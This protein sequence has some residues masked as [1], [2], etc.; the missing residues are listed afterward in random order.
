MK[1]KVLFA[2]VAL[3]VIAVLVI[4]SLYYSAS[5]PQNLK[6]QANSTKEGFLLT[7]QNAYIDPTT[8]ALKGPGIMT[9]GMIRG[10]W[11]KIK[12]GVMENGM[13]VDADPSI[14][15]SVGNGFDEAYANQK[16]IQS[17]D[18]KAVGGYQ[19]NEDLN[20]ISKSIIKSSNNSN[21][22]LYSR[23]GAKAGKMILEPNSIRGFTDESAMPERDKN[24]NIYVVGTGI[25]VPS[26]NIN[27][28]RILEHELIG[29]S[30]GAVSHNK[31][32]KRIPTKSGTGMA[33][34]LNDN[35]MK[36]LVDAGDTLAIKD[37]VTNDVITI[38][39]NKEKAP[40]N[41][42]FIQGTRL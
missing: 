7:S 28:D 10:D 3:L 33:E 31:K 6:Q 32:A 18:D 12:N 22:N 15:V 27:V 9:N 17:I 38:P 35:I 37:N 40:E 14:G 20:E 11:N 4:V 30:F 36:T 5:L 16:T 1:D 42:R 8:G 25:Y 13:A 23:A 41:Y 34:D 2:I 29:T 24:R 39:I 19:S 21:N 26:Y